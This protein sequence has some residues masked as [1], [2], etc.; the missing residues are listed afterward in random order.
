MSGANEP[1]DM[2]FDDARDIDFPD[3]AT[4]AGPQTKSIQLYDSLSM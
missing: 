1:V 4:H 3:S 2:P